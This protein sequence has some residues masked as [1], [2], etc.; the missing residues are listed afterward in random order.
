MVKGTKICIIDGDRVGIGTHIGFFSDKHC[1][2]IG[3][4]TLSFLSI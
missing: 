1:A 4:T 3:S 2:Q